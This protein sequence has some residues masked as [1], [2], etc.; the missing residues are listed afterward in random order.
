[1]EEQR[2]KCWCP[3]CKK[4]YDRIQAMRYMIICVECH[5][6]YDEKGGKA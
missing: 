3:K 4:N 2:I 5:K 1:M 6:E